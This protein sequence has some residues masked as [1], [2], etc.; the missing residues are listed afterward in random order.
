MTIGSRNGRDRC[1]RHLRNGGAT[2]DRPGWL[3]HSPAAMADKPRVKAP[4]Q[5]STPEGRRFRPDEAAA[6]VRRRRPRGARRHPRARQRSASEGGEAERERRAERRSTD[7]GCTLPRRARA[8]GRATRSSSPATRTRRGT[9]IRRRAARTTASPAI[10]GSTTSRSSPRA[11]STTSSTA[12]SSS[13]TATTCPRRPSTQL[14]AFYDDHQ[15]GTLL[16]PL[17]SLGN[18]I[19]LGAWVSRRDERTGTGTSRSATTFDEDAVRVLPRRSS[20]RGPSASRPTRSARDVAV[21]HSFGRGG[22][23]GQTRPA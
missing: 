13:C 9:P 11:S 1:G 3:L 5:R 2:R 18:K 21:V 20:S 19:A 12:A 4:K 7:A 22:G 17:P 15:T 6:H 23:T 8:A 10:F 14:R 16:A